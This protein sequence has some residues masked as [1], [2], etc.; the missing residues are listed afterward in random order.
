MKKLI[1]ILGLGLMIG[2]LNINKAEAQVRVSVNIDIHPAWGPSGYDYAEFYFIPEI[3]I[4]YDIVRRLFVYH[5]GNRWISSAYLPM[6]YSHYDFYSLYK[7]VLTDIR[8]PWRYNRNHRSLYANYF[9]VYNQMP[10]Y[11]MSDYRYRT[12]RVNYYGWVEPRYMPRNSGRPNSY[13]YSSNTRNGRIVESRSTAPNNRREA[14]S[15]RSIRN[16]AT[17]NSRGSVNSNVNSRSSNSRNDNTSVRSNSGSQ[18]R[19]NAAVNNQNSSSR[20][21]NTSV[22]SNSGN[23]N[24]N[25]S[26][27]NNQSSSSRNNN[28]TVRSSSGRNNDNNSSSRSTRG[29]NTNRSEN[30]RPDRR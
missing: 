8:N 10:I 9:Y 15:S 3:N 11:Y 7:V 1:F 27:I 17:V 26:T 4:Y 24:R 20:N 18:N 28:T 16:D 29:N 30:R 21:N 25:N 19:N 23:Q 14:V 2:T 6:A 13:N 12:A 22:R 5:S